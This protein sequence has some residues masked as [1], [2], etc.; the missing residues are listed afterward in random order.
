[1]S[2][3]ARTFHEETLQY[4][5]PMPIRPSK[6]SRQAN[7]PES[8]ELHVAPSAC[9][10]RMAISNRKEHHRRRLAHLYISEEDIVSGCY[11]E[12]IPTAVD[13]L[14]RRANP[15]PR[16]ISIIV[17][18]I[19]D[20]LGTDHQALKLLLSKQFPDVKFCLRRVD[21]ICID[22]GMPPPV[23][24]MLNTFELLE[25][26]GKKAPCVNLIG[27]MAE[28]IEQSELFDLCKRMGLTVRQLPM[29]QTFDD[30]LA[31]ADSSVN[32]VV[33]PLGLTAGQAMEKNL[34]IPCLYKPGS[35]RLE[36]ILCAYADIA[37]ATGKQLPDLTASTQLAQEKITA[38]RDHLQ[39]MPIV[40]D[41]SADLRPLSLA[42]ALVEYGFHVRLVRS[43]LLFDG[44]RTDLEWFQR[45]HPEIDVIDDRRLDVESMREKL[46]D[47]MCVGF[48]SGY[49]LGAKHLVDFPD[50]ELDYGFH[51]LYV[52]LEKMKTAY[53]TLADYDAIM[54]E[55]EAWQK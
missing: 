39:A 9:G 15:R 4:F 53:D 34:S 13:E 54:R 23:N 47:C 45:E 20:L 40:V 43:G 41:G 11:E 6:K 37:I 8:Y 12:L 35:Y 26:S 16:A 1:M 28:V 46:G 3:S 2:E 22:N 14:L 44:D 36:D 52:L 32:L 31:M 25:Y 18:C 38:T 19:D 50:L 24:M 48:S 17:T 10:R 51:A 33:T 5:T 29:C 42:R 30:F 55:S 49:L 27:N 7:I 21:P